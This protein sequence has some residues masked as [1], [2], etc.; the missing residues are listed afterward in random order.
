[1]AHQWPEGQAGRELRRMLAPGE[2]MLGW[3][4]GQSGAVLVATDQRAI[5]IKLG[6]AASGHWYWPFGTM[7]RAWPYRQISRVELHNVERATERAGWVEIVTV[8]HH[9]SGSA[10]QRVDFIGSDTWF[11]PLAQLLCERLARVRQAEMT[12]PETTDTDDG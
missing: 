9:V 5:I 10:D 7:L 12:T 6:R 3:Q 2:R 4:E 1:M 11:R 8:D